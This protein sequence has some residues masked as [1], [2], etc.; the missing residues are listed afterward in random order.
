MS[1]VWLGCVEVQAFRGGYLLFP[2][3]GP[4]LLDLLW[5]SPARVHPNR[6]QKRKSKYKEEM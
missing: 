3:A 5:L 6:S 1:T 2:L 4:V